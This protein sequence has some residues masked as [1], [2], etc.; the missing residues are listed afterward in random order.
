MVSEIILPQLGDTMTE[1]T[2][3]A[4]HKREGEWVAQGEPLF[5]VLTDKA[6]LEVEATTAGYLRRIL[7]GAGETVP[8]AQPIGYLSAT[9]EEPLPG[10]GGDEV[11]KW[12]GDTETESAPVPVSRPEPVTPSAPARVVASPRARRLAETAGVDLAWVTPASRSGRIVEADVQRFLAQQAAAPVEACPAPVPEA[13]PPA[14][15]AGPAVSAI[16][17]TGIRQ[18]I[19]ERMAQSHREVARVTLTTEADATELVALRRRLNARQ[20][21]LQVSYTDLLVKIV[22]LALRRH[23]VLNSTLVG[24]AI[25]VLPHIHIGLAVDTERGLL[26]PVLRDADQ[27]GI[28]AIGRE[29]RELA[30]RARVG[31][32]SP[33]ELRGSTFTLTNLGMYDIDAFTPLVNPPETAILGVGRIVEK[34]VAVQGQIALRHMLTL[35]LSFDHR[36]V[37]GGPAA[38]FLQEIKHLVE[39]PGLMLL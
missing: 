30:E 20:P 15:A 33:D 16:P 35:S 13:P 18:R 24:D 39:E 2:I 29:A 8:V 23:P 32:L 37:D 5:E 4:W 25:R 31:Q 27:K 34:P 9:L 17:F 38:R 28:A 21:E 22:A 26:V 12:Q 10:E 36:V 7:H 6:T 14:M 1:G 19:A 3:V 11:T